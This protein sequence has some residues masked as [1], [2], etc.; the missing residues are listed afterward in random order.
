M[1]KICASR[2]PAQIRQSTKTL[3]RSDTL[4]NF[5]N[6][7]LTMRNIWIHSIL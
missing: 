5:N 1:Q 6:D 3:I 4:F 2:Q 7:F